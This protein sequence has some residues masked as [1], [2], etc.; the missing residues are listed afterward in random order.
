MRRTRRTREQIE[1]LLTEFSKTGETIKQFCQQHNISAGTFH[2][3]QSRHKG[4][5]LKKVNGSGFA[6]ITVA[7][8]STGNLFAEVKGIRIYQPVS[9]AYIKELLV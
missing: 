4:K 1:N 2:K 5:V 6:A 9:A 8:L 3:W 7:P